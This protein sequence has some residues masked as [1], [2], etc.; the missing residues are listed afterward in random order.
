MAITQVDRDSQIKSGTGYAWVTNTSTGAMSTTGTSVTASSAVATDANGL[1]VASVTT[2]AQLAYLQGLTS[3]VNGDIIFVNSGNLAD[4]GISSANLFLRTGTVAAT[5][6]F[7][8]GSH[9]INNLS[10]P[11]SPQD[12][13]TKNYVD[14]L[15]NG[16]TWKSEVQAATT[17][18]LTAT[19]SN[20]AS[21]V[22][23]TLTNS[24]TQAA[25]SVDGYSA[26]LNDRI[27]VKNQTTTFQNGIYYVSTV[28]SGSTNWVLTRS[29]DMDTPAE[30][31]AATVLVEEGTANADTGWICTTQPPVTIGTTAITFVLF[32]TVNTYFAGN[33]LDLSGN[34]FSISTDNSLTANAG[35]SHP[36]LIVKESVTGA[37]STVADG[38][39]VQVDNSTVAISG[40]Q[41][42]VKAG[43][44]TNTQVSS[45][46]AIAYS[47]LNLSGSIVNSDIN[48]SAAIAAS[49]LAAAGSSTQIQY[50]NSGTFGASADF[51][52]TNSTDTLT[53]TGNSASPVININKDVSPSPSAI[54]FNSTDGSA[55]YAGISFL[56]IQ[57][58]PTL[59]IGNNT[60]NGPVLIET[61]DGTW[62]FGADG[63]LELQFPGNTITS[64]I[65][66]DDSG[67]NSVSI[68]A[69][70]T[71]TATY[72]LYWPVAQSTGTQVLT[73]DGSGNLSWAST[74]TT[75]LPSAEIF[76]GNASNVATATAVTG[77][78]SI[79]NTGVTSI[80][81]GLAA[82]IV[83]REVPSG[84][85]N[86]SNV[87][88]TLAHTPVAGTE[89]IYLNG[90]LQNVGGGNDYT[91]SGATITFVTAPES[92]SV[93]LVN[94]I[95]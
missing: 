6:A 23:A 25:F 66:F 75:V 51:T 64:Y 95:K 30:V 29:L 49:K 90:L 45:S 53:I 8:L 48:A 89:C 78:V 50:N 37:I 67:S 65:K 42:I 73:N 21:G 68:S 74:L 44:I 28:G 59:L 16:I 7:N 46:A 52:W 57:S 22:G 72:S 10:D 43:G 77:D 40:N 36:S 84:T 85:I 11:T 69:P 60:A 13:A 18:N 82:H 19:Y 32:G 87:T 80:S 26:S 5:G 4:A 41:V 38:I 9:Q 47:K 14:N 61:E 92:G 15:V 93:I 54:K 33:G 27:L 79:T 3:L 31:P 34:T 83:T 2:A 88:F 81:S 12:A 71:V 35:N 24:G 1:P 86:G 17:A 39:A 62:N 76:V 94:Y 58:L 63:G 91:I 56:T 70:M 20:G 55:S